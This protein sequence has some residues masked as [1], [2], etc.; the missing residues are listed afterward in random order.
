MTIK[1]GG[2]GSRD[3]T[4]ADAVARDDQQ[5]RLVRVLVRRAGEP[6]TYA[7]LRDAG[8]ELPASLVSEIELAGAE[9][10]RCYTIGPGGRPLA[11]VRLAAASP[12][13][14]PLPEAAASPPT[15][16]RRGEP[17]SIRREIFAG[18]PTFGRSMRLLAPVALLAAAAITVAVVVSHGTASSKSARRPVG[19]AATSTARSRPV[20]VKAPALRKTAPARLFHASHVSRVN[21]SAPLLGVPSATPA[22]PRPPASPTTSAPSPQAGSGAARSVVENFYEAAAQHRYPTAWALADT[23]MRNELGGYASFAGE[24][25]SVRAITFHAIEPVGSAAGAATFAVQTTSVQ[26]NT[27]QQCSGTVRTV[28]QTSAWLVDSISIHC[29]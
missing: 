19:R 26:A 7:E 22:A 5:E 24:M 28:Q 2:R 13:E 12:V 1:T 21:T 23:N 4:H 17:R 14:L 11:A 18:T 10:D 8:I 3:L 9:I 27:T 15:P 29:T 20:I 6:V 16:R 25:S